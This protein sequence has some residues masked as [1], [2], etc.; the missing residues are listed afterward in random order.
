MVANQPQRQSSNPIKTAVAVILNST[1]IIPN[2]LQSYPKSKTT[3]KPEPQAL[4]ANA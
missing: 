3:Q 2:P 4:N 1:I